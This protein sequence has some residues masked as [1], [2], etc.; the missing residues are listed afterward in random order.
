MKTNMFKIYNKSSEQMLEIDGGSIDMIITSPPYNIG[1]IYGANKDNLDFSDF[2][3]LLNG[4]VKES[5]RALK[6]TGRLIVECA[7][8]IKTGELYVEL[9]SMIQFMCL[10]EGFSIE[11]RFINFVSSD[12]GVTF[13]EH[14]WKED[15]TTNGNAHSNCHQVMV[16]SKAHVNFES[17]GEILYI[18]YQPS[19]EHPCPTPNGICSFFLNKY[20]KSNSN[21]KVLDPFMGTGALGVEVLKRNGDFFGYELDEKIFKIAEIN[22]SKIK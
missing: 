16:F 11:N 7:D 4:F 18:N 8:T 19:S 9:A 20:F 22:L 1:T 21:Y 12:G 13:L 6:D 10:K 17:T 2:K 15:Y 3:Q 14:G 5:F